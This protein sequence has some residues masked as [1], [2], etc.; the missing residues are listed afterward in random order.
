MRFYKCK[1]RLSGSRDNEVPKTGMTAADIVLM[2]AIHGPDSVTN[3]IPD[4][5]DDKLTKAGVLERVSAI[6]PSKVIKETFPGGSHLIPEEIG[7][8]R[9]DPLWLEQ[10]K[11]EKLT[12]KVKDASKEDALKALVG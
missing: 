2:E 11:T 7:E 3:I 4:G 1:V 10:T 6:Y 12:G 5:R 9:F 8:E